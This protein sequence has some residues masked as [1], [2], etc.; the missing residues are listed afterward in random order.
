MTSTEETSGN[1]PT[2]CGFRTVAPDPLD[3][4]C[5]F[6]MDCDSF[7]MRLSKEEIEDIR[8]SIFLD[9]CGDDSDDETSDGDESMLSPTLLV[10]TERPTTPTKRLRWLEDAEDCMSLSSTP[11]MHQAPA[12]RHFE[13]FAAARDQKRART[14][15][16]SIAGDGVRSIEQPAICF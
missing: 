11:E 10:D 5:Q 6:S 13:Q 4:E 3:N 16:I 14:T 7:E 15:E 1:R 8:T 2:M 12:N 9:S